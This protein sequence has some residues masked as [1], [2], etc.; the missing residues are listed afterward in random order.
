MGIEENAMYTRSLIPVFEKIDKELENG[1]SPTLNLSTHS[2]EHWIEWDMIVMVA[3]PEHLRYLSDCGKNSR[4]IKP[5]GH[6]RN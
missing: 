2:S 1:N 4:Y 5:F 3:L 6:S